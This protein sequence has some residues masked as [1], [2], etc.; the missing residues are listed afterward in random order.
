MV[1]SRLNDVFENVDRGFGAVF[2]AARTGNEM[3]TRLFRYTIDELE[4][5]QRERTDLAKQ[6]LE[7][8]TDLVGISRSVVETWQLRGRRRAGLARTFLD[9][10]SDSA[11]D[12]RKAVLEVVRSG[13]EG[14]RAGFE[15]ARE[16]ASEAG[17]ELRERAHD[18]AERA[19]EETR[20]GRTARRKSSRR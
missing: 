4:R 7:A 14:G 13:R 3:T 8:P 9:E 5:T 16:A 17:E 18:L 1:S 20:N 11:A 15:A 12:S 2:D 19:E 10:L 6:W